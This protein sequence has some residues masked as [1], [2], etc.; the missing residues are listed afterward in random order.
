[1]RLHPVATTAAA[2]L[3]LLGIYTV[4]NGEAEARRLERVR[5]QILLDYQCRIPE[6]ENLLSCP[7]LEPGFRDRL[8]Q[9]LDECLRGRTGIPAYFPGNARLQGYGWGFALMAMGVVCLFYKP[10]STSS[11]SMSHED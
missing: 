11:V 1:M 7:T 8:S 10:Q 3:V 2:I 9:E 4:A 5:A 6:L